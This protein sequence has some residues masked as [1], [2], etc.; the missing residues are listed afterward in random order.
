MTQTAR[1]SPGSLQQR[2]QPRPY[3]LQKQDRIRQLIWGAP[4][5]CSL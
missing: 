1:T 5:A 4:H 3:F 2:P